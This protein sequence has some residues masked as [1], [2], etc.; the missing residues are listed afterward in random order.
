MLLMFN[1]V[2][3]SLKLKKKIHS[4]YRQFSKPT[5]QLLSLSGNPCNT[6]GLQ[7][8]IHNCKRPQIFDTQEWP[9][10]PAL[11]SIENFQSLGS[12]KAQLTSPRLLRN[13]HNSSSLLTMPLGK[14]CCA[15]LHGILPQFGAVKKKVQPF[16][17]VSLAMSGYAKNL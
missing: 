12:H 6:P 14:S 15:A 11:R 2:K 3:L 4:F 5:L 13:Y 10:L 17:Q 1:K 7:Y 16:I 8:S 9:L